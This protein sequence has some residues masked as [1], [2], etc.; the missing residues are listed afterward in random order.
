MPLIFLFKDPR[1][2]PTAPNALPVNPNP[3]CTKGAALRNK[4]GAALAA[5]NCVPLIAGPI[6]AAATNT[7]PVFSGSVF[8]PSA[9]PLIIASC[10]LRRASTCLSVRKGLASACL[11]V[12]VVTALATRYLVTPLLAN[13]AATGLVTLRATLSSA[14]SYL[15]LGFSVTPW[16]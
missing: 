12:T 8:N 2:F 13:A 14:F 6:V 10:S 5:T 11:I 15:V 9:A 16:G 7:T 1:P 3:F 4:A